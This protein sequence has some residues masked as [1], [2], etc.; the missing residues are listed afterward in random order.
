M[1]KSLQEVPAAFGRR[2][3]REREQRGWSLRDLGAECGMNAS[4]ILR[5]EGGSD[6]ALSNAVAIAAGLGLP[7][8]VLLTEPECARCDDRPPAGFI[9]A[10]CRREGAA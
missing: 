1:S 9:C 2:I 6:A 5:I 4:T 8:S 7:L 3:K 10:A